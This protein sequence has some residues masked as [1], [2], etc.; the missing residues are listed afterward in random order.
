LVLL[1]VPLASALEA[2]LIAALAARAEVRAIVPSGDVSAIGRLTRALGVQPE[3]LPPREDER[4]LDRLSRQLFSRAVT[5]APLDASVELFSAPG[6]S[7]ECVEIARRVLHAARQGVPFDRMAVVTHSPERYRA[8][9]AE[10]LRRAEI[11]AYFSRGT[12][13]P[14]PA[15]RALL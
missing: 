15:G 7:R 1:D 8:H 3:P 5:G 9:L 12:V 11:P 14:D 6:E 10:A 4:A 13:R 2:E